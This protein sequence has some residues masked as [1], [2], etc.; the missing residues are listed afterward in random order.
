MAAYCRI[1]ND[2]S[3]LEVGIARQ[4]SDCGDLAQRIWPGATVRC[5]VDNDLSAADPSVER[6][7]WQALLD[8]LRSGAVDELVAYDQSRLTRQPIGVGATARGP[9]SARNSLRLHGA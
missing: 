3:G 9:W 2:P 6:P 4:R 1:S 5:F 7:G 8:A